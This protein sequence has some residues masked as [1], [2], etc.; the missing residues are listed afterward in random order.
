MSRRRKHKSPKQFASAASFLAFCSIIHSVRNAH[1]YQ[2]DEPKVVVLCVPDSQDFSFYREVLED[3]FQGWQPNAQHIVPDV[4]TVGLKAT[5][6]KDRQRNRLINTLVENEKVVLIAESSDALPNGIDGLVDAVVQIQKPTVRH[7][8][9][10]ARAFLGQQISDTDAERAALAPLSIVAVTWRRGRSVG[11]VIDAIKL[12][13]E[14]PSQRRQGP[15]LDDLHG[16]GE[17]STWGQELAKDINDWRARKIPWDDVDRGALISGPPGCGKT[18]Y[19]QALARTCNA[20]FVSGSL[21]QWQA[22]GHLGDLLKAMRS[23]FAEATRNAPA[24][25]FIDEMDSVGDRSRLS[26]H[27]AHYNREV[28]NGL[29][30]CLDGVGG[31]EGVVVIGATN[32]PEQLDTALIRPGR[33]DRIIRIPLPDHDARTGILKWHLKGSLVGADLNEVVD[34]TEGYTGASLEK[35]VRDARRIAR[36]ARR[37]MTV[38]DLTASLPLRLALPERLQHR[39]AVHEAGHVLVGYVLKVGRLVDVSIATSLTL[40]DRDQQSGGQTRFSYNSSPTML[41]CELLG[42]ITTMLGGLAAEEVLLGSRSSG[43][44]GQE[45]ADLHMAT[46]CALNIEASFGLGDQLS[47]LL[48]ANETEPLALLRQNLDLR[49]RVDKLLSNEFNHAKSIVSTHRNTVELIATEL[50]QT[51]SLTGADVEAIMQQSLVQCHT[52]QECTQE[53]D[54]V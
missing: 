52:A 18:T 38:D 39:L 41:R 12:A 8:Q 29:L 43:G 33:L 20:H 2:G 21:A 9:A 54:H 47:Y 5:H 4:W 17:A 6:D 22:R 48:A 30:E 50:L 34:G 44:G 45:G 10:A 16:M 23:A 37:A 40:D 51:Q 25:L 13:T 49:Q 46:L 19:A 27:H 53:V 3:A 26:D 32:Y 11:T 36:R 24:I 1:I 31:R 15:T 7:I 28:T 14:S 42:E 35:L